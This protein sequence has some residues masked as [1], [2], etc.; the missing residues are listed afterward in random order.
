MGRH[1]P[2]VHPIPPS[3]HLTARWRSR[4]AS[5][6]VLVVALMAMAASA[7]AHTEATTSS[8]ADGAVL[9]E[10]PAR[11]SVT[12]GGEV[13]TPIAEIKVYDRTSSRVDLEPAYFDP[14]DERRVVAD[15]RPD[16]E[17]GAYVVI[18]RA[19]SYDGHTVIGSFTFAIGPVAAMAPPPGARAATA[20][21]LDALVSLATAEAGPSAFV[22]G[23]SLAARVA[24]GLG[25]LLA[26]GAAAFLV[27]VQRRRPDR[28]LEQSAVRRWIRRGARLGFLATLVSLP[29]QAAA[30]AGT[31]VLEAVTGEAFL[32]V[33]V[34][35][36][37]VAA[38]VRLIALGPLAVQRVDASG[39][40]VAVLAGAGLVSLALDGHSVSQGSLPVMFTADLAHLAAGAVWFGGLVALLAVFRHQRLDRDARGAAEVIAAF[41]GIAAAALVGLT[42]AG[43][44]MART[45]VGTPSALFTTPYG[46]VLL[47]KSVVVLLV[48]LLGG[49]NRRWLVPRVQR[50]VVAVPAGGV[51]DTLDVGTGDIDLP[52]T[53]NADDRAWQLL[54][55]TVRL[56][57]TGIVVALVLTGWLTG[58]APAT[59]AMGG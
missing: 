59:S 31:S 13:E 45:L 41:S 9:A 29:A 6:L 48:A 58:L 37:G 20:V 27:L 14:A 55:R 17:P 18:W 23:V 51:V 35:P 42:A 56:E 10:V 32:R 57:V 21:E 24:V 46:R 38:L 4:A 7:L 1:E 30:V 28:W 22:E 3:P 26:A 8:P 49:Y 25:T 12:F 39:A 54:S 52:L 50:A 47:A 34:S 53:S 11:V 33:L 19:V 16:V 2:T 5:V 36:F 43:L 40:S 44:V 15:L